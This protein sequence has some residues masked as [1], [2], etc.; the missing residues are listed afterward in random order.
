MNEWDVDFDFMP[1]VFIR[2][3]FDGRK[4]VLYGNRCLFNSVCLSQSL[5][6]VFACKNIVDI[7]YIR[8]SIRRVNMRV[9]QC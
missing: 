5:P 6:P 2:C 4:Y 9:A 7:L 3:G 8:Q 1:W